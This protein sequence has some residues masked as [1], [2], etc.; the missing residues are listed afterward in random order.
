MKYIQLHLPSLDI[1]HPFMRQKVW[2]K[3]ET[4]DKGPISEPQPWMSADDGA[5]PQKCVLSWE[6]AKSTLHIG[7]GTDTKSP[8]QSSTDLSIQTEEGSAWWLTCIWNSSVR[9]W[10]LYQMAPPVLL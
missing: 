8:E 3:E 4:S 2:L 7:A 6:A 1:C 9:I 10:M 5:E